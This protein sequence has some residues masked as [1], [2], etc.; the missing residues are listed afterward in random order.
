M[1]INMIFSIAI[2]KLKQDF[3]RNL[4]IVIPIIVI[5]ILLLILNMIQY[6][7]DA[8]IDSIRNNIELRTI[9][10]ISYSDSNYEE[11]IDKLEN[12]EHI[13]MIADLYESNIFARQVL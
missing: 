1:K 12:I 5:T 4:I 7:I 3:R 8:H 9:S 11:V 2:K 13:L 6:S 10:G